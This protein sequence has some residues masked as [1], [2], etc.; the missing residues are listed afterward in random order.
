MSLDPISRIRRFNRAVTRETGVLDTSFLGRGRPLGAA[1]VLHA[2]GFDGADLESVRDALDL[3]KA[4][5]SRYLGSKPMTPSRTTA[6]AS[7]W[8][9]TRIRKPCSPRW[10]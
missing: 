2:I 10:T 6:P 1:R 5:L 4:L 3:E 7:C 8:I 9:A